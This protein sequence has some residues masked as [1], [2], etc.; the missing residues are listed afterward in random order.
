M[1]LFGSILQGITG[2]NAAGDAA[3]AQENAANKGL[4]NSQQNQTSAIGAQQGATDYERAIQSPFLQAGQ[5]AVQN[6]GQLLSQPGGGWNQQ[7]SAPTAQQ[8]EQTPGYEF[9]RQQGDQ[10]LQQSAAARGGLLTGGT[11]KA[12]DQYNTGLA[13]NTYQQTYNNALQ[14]YQQN[15]GQ[16]QNQVHNLGQL[17]GLGEGATQNLTNLSQAGAQNTGALDYNFAGQQN[18]QTTNYGNAKASGYIGQA[19]AWNSAINGVGNALGGADTS[20][21]PMGFLKSLI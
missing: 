20:S 1:S 11:A 19:N 12:L 16:Y 5:G 10:A 2:S 18:Q 21:G 13:S 3:K 15:Y 7:F 17:A 14:A 4:A 6:L 8:A 9:T